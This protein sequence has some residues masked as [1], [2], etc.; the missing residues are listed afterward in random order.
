MT[1][2]AL[3]AAVF[4]I[5]ALMSGVVERAPLSFPIIF[6]GLGMLIGER[7]LDFISIDVH[8]PTL[9]FIGI[10]TLSLVL[11]LDALNLR[12]DDFGEDWH[13][14]VLALGPGVIIIVGII[15]VG[16]VWLVDLNWTYALLVGAI[17]A[18]TDPVV[19]REVVRDVRIPGSVR[20]ALTAEAGTNDLVVLPTVLILIAV[21]LGDTGGVLGWAEFLVRLLVIGPLVGVIIGAGGAYLMGVI[22]RRH[23]IRL[24]YQALFGVGLVLASFTG[25]DAL[26]GDGFLAAFA[27]G[28]AVTYFNMQLC[29]C[30]ME[31]GEVTAEMAMLFSF[32]L[33]GAVLSTLVG[34]IALAPALFF[35]AVVIGFARPAAFV[36]ALSRARVSNVARFFL[37]WFGPRGLNSLL[38][39]LL[40]VQAGVPG[41]ERLLAIVGVV[42]IASV[43]LHGSSATPLAAWYGRQ[44]AGVT[45]DEERSST[46][47]SIFTGHD[48]SVS[49][50][51]VDELATL[52]ESEDPPVVLDVR[53]RSQ[54]DRDRGEIPGSV[55]VPPDQIVEWAREQDRKRMVVAYCT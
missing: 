50:I 3:V 48:D 35:A 37:G 2:F 45:L 32:V 7:G 30:F 34:T 40:V 43:V 55:R 6:L 28:F 49:R 42:V 38:L 52:L 44:T 15:A 10:L 14:P 19:L 27:A 24:E 20:R 21:A 17:L 12:L 46:A 36:I 4:T 23:G 25:A 39:A 26:G 9:E 16:G 11:F 29:H 8:D 31:Y 47:A 18:S 22:D 51:T 13:L 33:F 54:Y 5:S 41:S 1:A 53:S